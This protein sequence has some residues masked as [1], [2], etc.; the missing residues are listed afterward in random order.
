MLIS[1]LY[2]VLFLLSTLAVFLLLR[3]ISNRRAG[4]YI[5]LFTLISVVCLAY[6][7][8]SVA[9]DT[10][11]AIVSNQFTYF[12]GT[13][14]L[15]FFLLCILD[16]CGM[17]MPKIV[18]CIITFLCFTFLFLA[19]SAGHFTI[20]YKSVRFE[21][22]MGASHLIME[23]GPLRI[24][25]LVFVVINTLAPMCIVIYSFFQKKKISYIYT[26]A[27]GLI[28]LAIVAL[29]FIEYAVGLGF[30]LLDRKSVV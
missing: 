9:K 12:D 11:M 26:F 24:W 20:F 25:F 22:Y 23:F 17:K 3:N 16:I 30:D 5:I 13:F 14:I 8:Y 21:R 10:G 15:L 1:S 2:I 19:F 28:E 6:F 4:Y 27:L 29:Y 7:S 18:G